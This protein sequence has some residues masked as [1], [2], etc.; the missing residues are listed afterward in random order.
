MASKLRMLDPDATIHQRYQIIRNFCK[1]EW[2]DVP[3]PVRNAA[4]VL[5]KL[6]HDWDADTQ[7]LKISDGFLPS[8]HVLFYYDDP[9]LSAGS[10]LHPATSLLPFP[11]YFCQLYRL[12]SEL[13]SLDHQIHQT[14]RSANSV[15]RER[16]TVTELCRDKVLAVNEILVPILPE[17]DCEG[18]ELILPY[19]VELFDNHDTTV[20]AAWLL[21]NHIGRAL[22]PTS[23]AKHVLPALVRLYSGENPTRKHLKLYERS[24]LRQLLIR[25][26]LQIFLGHFATLLV[27]AVAAY[28]DFPPESQ[29]DVIAFHDTD[30]RTTPSG[31]LAGQSKSTKLST[32]SIE[33]E[34]QMKLIDEH[35]RKQRSNTKL[36][37]VIELSEVT[38]FG[39][40]RET[41]TE[42]D[43]ELL[44]ESILIHDYEDDDVT[45][46]HAD[47]SEKSSNSSGEAMTSSARD[48]DVIST[49]SEN[50]ESALGQSLGKLS[51]H[52]VSRLMDA[53]ERR[54]SGCSVDADICEPPLSESQESVEDVLTETDG[55]G[56]TD[57]ENEDISLD[58]PQTLTRSETEEFTQNFLE[59]YDYRNE[60]NICDVAA[61]S[62][63]WISRRLGPLLTAKFFSRN[64]LRML[65]LC[66]IGDEQLEVDFCDGE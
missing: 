51:V 63:K 2:K 28:R 56:D 11:R 38:D 8:K 4:T 42:S 5:L 61:E 13:K 41:D 66:Y 16:E 10:L 30:T 52:S 59:T 64:L 18:V 49:C 27:E 39:Q 58:L 22:G 55:G 12:I 19:V 21:F 33:S 31:N 45:C 54:P 34:L 44:T 35:T 14:L 6:D 46:T 3:R 50:S 57:A 7:R 20:S 53:C 36:E 62:I 65:A 60:C 40:R 43:L 9:C 37:S 48:D 1:Q 29:R 32:A 26:G 47:K 24:F 23:T 25:L 17:M 15:W